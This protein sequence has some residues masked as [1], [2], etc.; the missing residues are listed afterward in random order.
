MNDYMVRS[1]GG[2]QTI[3]ISERLI[4]ATATYMRKIRS[5]YACTVSATKRSQSILPDTGKSWRWAKIDGQYWYD[6]NHI[7]DRA[8]SFYRSKLPVKDE[9]MQ[10]SNGKQKQLQT[11]IAEY[12]LG[13]IQKEVHDLTNP[14][15][16]HYFMFEAPV[17]FSASDA[18]AMAE[19][20]CWFNLMS[21]WF[22][23]D[24]YK[25]R[26]GLKAQDFWQILSDHFRSTKHPFI[27]TDTSAS[28]RKKILYEWPAGKERR[29]EQLD[30][31]ISKKHG[32]QYA[33]QVGK[34]KMVDPE[35]GE[36]MEF[37]LH[38]ALIY[39]LWMN[40]GKP[41]K[42]HKTGEVSVYNEYKKQVEEY[43]CSAISESTVALYLRRFPNR[44]LMSLERDGSD[45]FN[46][47][48]KPYI[49]SHKPAF[50]SSIWVADFSGSKLL[51]RYMKESWKDGKKVSKWTTASG[52]VLRITDCATDY[53]VAWHFSHSGEDFK[54][55]L[56]ALRTAVETNQ[57]YA[58][59]ELVTDNGP[60]FTC[61]DAQLRLPM[62]FDKHRKIELG[63]KQANKAEIYV[64]R[65]SNLARV[66]DNWCMSSFNASHIDNQANPDYLDMDNIPTEG[67]VIMQVEQLINKWNNTP[68][69]DGTIPAVE[70]AK[71]ERRNRDLQ[72]ISEHSGRYV[73]GKHTTY[74][75]DRC[76]GI[77][78]LQEGSRIAE[79]RFPNWE[80]DAITIDDALYGS[81][82]LEVKVVWNDKGADIYTPDEK[83]IL[84][85]LPL[86]K[87]HS[88][89][90]EA[91]D[92][93]IAALEDH[94]AS[95][96]RVTNT[97]KQFTE[98]V[99][100]ALEAIEKTHE[101]EPELIQVCADVPLVAELTY[102]MRAKLN[103]GRAKEEHN[104]V[105]R[106]KKEAPGD[107]SDQDFINQ[108]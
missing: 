40:P 82:R 97:A 63:N 49:R 88:T 37:D 13:I 48:Y 75:L 89:F 6:Y 74:T 95:K 61:K 42:L 15:D 47:T 23:N 96:Q 33:R 90:A 70:F 50:A 39:D 18:H 77:L 5:Q 55:V 73:F 78:Q 60:A 28:L 10:Q 25:K 16:A 43:G 108:L 34:F 76:R 52:Y 87:S 1:D 104:E 67:H 17:K 11:E 102:R 58:A 4:D 68:L 65:L 100:Q 94:I 24:D 3:W 54:Q 106:T 59:R 8:P 85:C 32:N 80:Q 93:T 107:T 62:L 22:K 7:P 30:S 103:G 36:I 14:K 101:P 38:E 9:I 64:K 21:I 41:N 56:T 105:M 99:L 35:T 81:T 46:S 29:Q 72:P 51:Y 27:N 26:C 20:R 98:N 45:H 2:V 86:Q 91:T 12:F 79:F 57:G 66:F 83:Y 84:T 71:Q 31:L 53:I 69:P 92:E 19:A 44:M